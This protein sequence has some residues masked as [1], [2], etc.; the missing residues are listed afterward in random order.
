MNEAVDLNVP[1]N[2]AADQEYP[3]IFI[4]LLKTSRYMK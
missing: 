3:G 4:Y 1:D 2:V